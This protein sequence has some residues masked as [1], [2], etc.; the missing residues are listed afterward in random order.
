MNEVEV[1]YLDCKFE[2]TNRPALVKIIFLQEN[3]ALEFQKIH[4]SRVID[5]ESKHMRR[6]VVHEVF[7]FLTPAHRGMFLKILLKYKMK[8][9]SPDWQTKH[10]Y[11][12]FADLDKLKKCYTIKFDKQNKFKLFLDARLASSMENVLKTVDKK[13]KSL[14]DEHVQETDLIELYRV[15]KTFMQK[16]TPIRRLSD[17]IDSFIHRD[18]LRRD[19]KVYLWLCV[20]F[21]YG[22]YLLLGTALYLLLTP[23]KYRVRLGFINWGMG[24]FEREEKSVETNK[25]LTFLKNQQLMMISLSSFLKHLFYSKNR[26]MVFG[27]STYSVAI[28]ITIALIH[29]F[30]MGQFMAGLI[31]YLLTLKY[32]HRI[33]EVPLPSFFKKIRFFGRLYSFNFWKTISWTPR[34]KKLT[35]TCILVENQR[36]F[37]R[38]GFTSARLP[39]GSII[40][41]TKFF[42]CQRRKSTKLR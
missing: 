16:V 31:F 33:P 29:C 14:V 10:G 28:I 6:A 2:P 8:R 20:W 32:K 13:P 1:Q 30:T 39:F 9:D 22:R 15:S 26:R 7:S 12:F 25:N 37:M 19:I 24:F 17:Q 35:K 3:H 42:R 23:L 11:I 38:E 40:R 27:I 21:F 41:S 18:D 5:I 34:V 4:E 36:W